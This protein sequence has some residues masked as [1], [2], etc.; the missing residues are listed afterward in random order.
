MSPYQWNAQDYAQSSSNQQ[1]W[2]RELIAKLLLNG[3]ENLLDIG[4]GDGKVSAELAA[5]LPRGSVLGID[6]S[7]DMITLAQQR[8]PPDS[9][10][11]LRFRLEDASRLPF[12]EQFE[13]VFSNATLHWVVDHRPVLHGI[14]R[15]LKPGGTML[16]QMGGRGNASETIQAIDEVRRRRKWRGYFGG[17]DFPFG[18][19]GPGEYRTWMIEAGLKPLRVELVPKDM[20]HQ[21]TAAF[22]AW[23][24]TTWLPYTQRVPEARR[25]AFISESVACYQAAHPPDSNG[26]VHVAMVRLEVEGL[27]PGI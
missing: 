4:C 22:E 19:Y 6:N 2:A 7:K 13:R 17:F 14:F 21:D 9:Y 20:L 1:Q 18:F 8:F 5:Q 3:D 23:I 24:R 26:G 25:Q 16:L 27:K 12:D 15:A 10:S 11:N